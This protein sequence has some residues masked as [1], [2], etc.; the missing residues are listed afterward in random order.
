LLRQRGDLTGYREVGDAAAGRLV[1]HED[2]GDGDQQAD[3]ENGAEN[4]E[5]RVDIEV[6]DKRQLAQFATILRRYRSALRG[7]L[8]ATV[9]AR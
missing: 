4:A 6:A 5:L 9:E 1:L 2:R 3:Q 8:S 7:R